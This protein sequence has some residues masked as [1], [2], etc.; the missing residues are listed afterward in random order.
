MQNQQI[1]KLCKFILE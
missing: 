1:V